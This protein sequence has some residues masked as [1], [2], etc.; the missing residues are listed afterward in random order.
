M[1]GN[2][3]MEEAMDGELLNRLLEKDSPYEGNS[4]Y[5]WIQ[6]NLFSIYSNPILWYFLQNIIAEQ[7]RY[8]RKKRICS[9]IQK[10]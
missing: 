6:V 8:R 2:M 7:Q 1:G 4:S 5:K 10:E 9:C 3:D